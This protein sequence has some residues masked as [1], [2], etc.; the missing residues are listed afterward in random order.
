MLSART[1]LMKHT[2]DVVLG[3]RN[4]KPLGIVASHPFPVAE[5]TGLESQHSALHHSPL[6][7]SESDICVHATQGAHGVVVSHPLCMR[8]ALGSIP[9][10]SIATRVEIRVV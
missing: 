4:P 9:S 7:M 2:A 10:V 8:K 5:G 6:K 3:R 1:E